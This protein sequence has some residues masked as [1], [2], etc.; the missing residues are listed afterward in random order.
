MPQTPKTYILGLKRFLKK[1]VALTRI[2]LP[3][4]VILGK[5]N[6]PGGV[7]SRDGGAQKGRQYPFGPRG[8]NDN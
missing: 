4:T 1:T 3:M 5:N 6:V 7:E 8:R 2:F